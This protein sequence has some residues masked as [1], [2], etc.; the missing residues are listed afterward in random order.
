MNESR[1]FIGRKAYSEF[2]ERYAA[3]VTTK[4]HNAL[5]E[6]PATMPLPSDVTVCVFSTRDVDQAFAVNISREAAQLFK[7]ST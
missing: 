4:P 1:Q 6:R 5:Y 3:A 7:R 2:A